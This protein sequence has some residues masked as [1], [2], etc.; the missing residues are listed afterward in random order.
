MTES[1]KDGV[2][3]EPVVLNPSKSSLIFVYALVN[4]HKV[5]I[6]V[7][8]GAT[9]T[10]INNR[11][12]HY[13]I[14]RN[15]ILKQSHS[16]LLAD[17]VAPFHVLGLVNL[18]IEFNSFRTTI[19]AHVAQEL[20]T[21]MIIGM[22]FINKYNMNINVKKQIVTFESNN[23]RAVLSIVHPTNSIKIPVVSS[24][25][26]ILPPRSTRNIS[27]SIPISSVSLPF[28]PLSSFK[29]YIVL[30]NNHRNLHFQNNCCD[31]I[32]SNFTAHSKAIRKG[33]PIGYLSSFSTFQHPR[34]FYCL[35][36]RYFGATRRT[37]MTPALISLMTLTDSTILS[38]TL[39]QTEIH[40]SSQNPH[41]SSE[42]VLISK[43]LLNRIVI[44]NL[45][46]LVDNSHNHQQK[47]DLLSL[48]LH[49]YDIFDTTKH[50][51]ART[52]IPHVINTVP[53]SPPAGRSYPQPDRE[54]AM[55]KLIQEFLEAGLI[56]ESNSPYVA[57]TILVKKKDQSYQLVVDYKRLNAITIKDSSPLPNMEDILQKLGKSFSYFFGQNIRIYKVHKNSI[58]CSDYQG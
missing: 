4:K 22:D 38:S 58:V 32:L 55:Y 53:H 51:I 20:C 18:S 16:F 8:T 39:S 24:N 49:F 46:S 11:I 35:S 52:P 15:T 57:P 9:K 19:T 12:L 10:F 31:I 7:D 21:D 28:F 25:T 50:T 13:I 37:G 27:V 43:N 44:N 17:G 26:V 54:E 14:T 30:H 29:H 45:N 41:A 36:H 56:S 34:T 3:S 1:S 42:E 6:L 48:L 40:G 2:D 47:P 5:K 23:Q 33:V